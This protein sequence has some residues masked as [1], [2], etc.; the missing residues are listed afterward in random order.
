MDRVKAEA[1]LEALGSV[2]EDQDMEPLDIV[3]CGAMVLL[4]RGMVRRP[5]RDIDGLGFVEE[6]D[7]ELV[8]RKP[9]L[10]AKLSEAIERVGNLYGEGRHWLSM[11]ATVLHD[12]T[13]LP[14]GIIMESDAR[15]FGD[16]LTVRLCSRRH[17]VFLKLWG[18][19]NRGEPDIG[20]LIEME[21]SEQEAYE[22]AAWCLEQDREALPKL[23]S[24]LEVIGHGD[25]AEKL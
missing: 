25:L 15:R 5:T 3:V 7:G 19:L 24:V 2:L 22:A 1:M 16:R 17:M 11:A 20:D 13:S 10:S 9:V 23:K 18:A 4:M 6:S 8:L 14:P 21:V 12:D